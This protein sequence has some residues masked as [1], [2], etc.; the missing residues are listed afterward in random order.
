MCACIVFFVDNQSIPD[1]SVIFE[2]FG[3]HSEHKKYLC[4]FCLNFY[5]RKI[6]YHITAL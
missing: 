1:H 6:L 2:N 3:P 4:P 5:S